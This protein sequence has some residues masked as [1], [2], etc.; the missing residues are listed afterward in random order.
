[1]AK[2]RFKFISAVHLILENDGRILLLRRYNTGYED[3]NYSL[4]AGHIDQGERAT[5]AMVRE[6]KEEIGIDISEGTLETI[7]VVHRLGDDQERIDFFMRADAWEG[8]PINGEQDKCDELFWCAM[9]D[10]PA[11]I[12][13]YVK[14]ALSHIQNGVFYSEFGWE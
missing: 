5:T 9:D 4:P 11:N 14:S 1:M 2:D 3:G 13:P 10:L 12:I 6:T 7:H 8:E